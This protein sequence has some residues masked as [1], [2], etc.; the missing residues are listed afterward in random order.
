MR[1]RIIGACLGL[2][3]VLAPA[4]A[5]AEP[6]STTD[7]ETV[8]G[9]VPVVGVARSDAASGQNTIPNGRYEFAVHGVHRYDG[10]TVAYWSVRS[11]PAYGQDELSDPRH[12]HWRRGG[13][14]NSGYGVSEV[15]LAAKDRGELY[16][17]LLHETG[18]E[19]LCT[20]V[21]VL[22]RGP[23]A[24]GQWQTVY[25]TFGELPD[26]VEEV[27]IHLDGYGTVVHAVPVTDGLPEPQVD[28]ETV[29]VGETQ[30]ALLASGEE[31]PDA[32]TAGPV[33][34]KYE[35]PVLLTKAQNLPAVTLDTIVDLRVQ[36][37]TIVGGY[38]AIA[39]AIQEALEAVV[40]P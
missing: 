36:K 11:A 10:G 29:L 39:L 24:R 8:G 7:V 28:A 1:A 34:A 21:L 18:S 9:E 6:A 20:D 22:D 35:T 25:A 4:V 14:G 16:T 23:E 19:C 5:T 13:F 12:F 33:A 31:F 15:T 32:L 30:H 38:E 37:V 17:T 27:S 3:L 2:A 26:D 40:Y